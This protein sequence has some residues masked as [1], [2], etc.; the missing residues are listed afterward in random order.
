MTSPSNLALRVIPAELKTQDTEIQRLEQT[1]AAHASFDLIGGHLAQFGSERRKSEEWQLEQAKTRKNRLLTEPWR[2]WANGFSCLMFVVI[3][4]PMAVRMKSADV[5]TTF[6]LCFL[7]IL[8]GYYPLLAFGVGQ[9]KG[10]D[11][12]PYAVWMSNLATLGLGLSFFRR[13]IRH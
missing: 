10:G 1:L 11:L 4:L 9:A 7:P 5:W 13:M 12:P 8:I 6:G 2:R 3:G